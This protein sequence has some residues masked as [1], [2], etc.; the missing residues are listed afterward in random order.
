MGDFFVIMKKKF[1][2]KRSDEFQEIINHRKFMRSKSFVIYTKI[3]KEE[4]ARIGISVPKK[5]GNAVVRNKTKRQIR[6]MIRNHEIFEGNLDVILIVKANY[7]RDTYEDN[8]KDLEKLLK[9][10]KIKNDM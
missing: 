3:K 10:V 1:R 2:I 4:H 9:Q 5:I 6:E 8:Q 7:L